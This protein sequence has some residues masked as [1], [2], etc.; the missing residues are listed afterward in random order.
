MLPGL[1]PTGAGCYTDLDH[2]AQ[3]TDG[4]KEEMKGALS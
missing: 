1:Q 4:V 3:T 2:W